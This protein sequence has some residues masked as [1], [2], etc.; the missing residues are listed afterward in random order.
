MKL[1]ADLLPVALPDVPKVPA[2]A[3]PRGGVFR[4]IDAAYMAGAALN[5]LDN[6]MRGDFVWAGVWRQRLALQCAAAAVNLTG[7][8]EDASAL[9]DTHYLRGVGDD[10]GPAGRTLMAWR[11]LTNRTTGCDEDLVRPVAEQH[12]GLQWDDALAE[13]VANAEDLLL[14]SPPAP[15]LAGEI[16]AAVYAARPDAELLGFWLADALLAQKLKWPIPV[17][18]LMGQVVSPIFK[19]GESRKRI[20]PGNEGW[21]RAVLLAY[22][23]AAAEACDLGIELAQ[24]A[25]KLMAVAPKLR[26]KGSGDVIDLLLSNDAVPGSW[27]SAKLS[28]RGT[29]RL[30]DRLGELGAVR[31]LS[32]RST[33][34]LY[35]L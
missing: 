18:L 17:P 10:P 23:T 29:R 5:S 4:D 20:R 13:V 8:R 9:R 33:F 21:S 1:S 26:A 16:A 25:A 31:E 2:W 30:F 27:S 7:R 15:V 11:R 35:G 19:P 34:R 12:F 28:A 24:R 14:S 22:A 32:G 3:R 6:L